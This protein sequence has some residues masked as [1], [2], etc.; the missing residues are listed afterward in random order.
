MLELKVGINGG[1][2]LETELG[3]Y[4]GSWVGIEVGWEDGNNDGSR[5]MNIDGL[6]QWL[7]DSSSMGSWLAVFDVPLEE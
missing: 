1:Q 3:N 2:L 5:L 6:I 7:F 4:Y